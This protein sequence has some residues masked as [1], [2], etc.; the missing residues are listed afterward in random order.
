[1]YLTHVRH[2]VQDYA[3]WRAAFDSNAP[4]LRECGALSTH[5]V[6][7]NGN[8]TD[9]AV[10]NTWPSEKEWRDF[11]KADAVSLREV[12]GVVGEPQWYGGEVL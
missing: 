12:G 2:T 11:L 8:P 4:L 3:R 1:M 9:I 5:I 6:V 7:V 10:I